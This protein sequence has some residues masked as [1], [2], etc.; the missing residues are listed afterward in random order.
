MDRAGSDPEKAVRQIPGEMDRLSL[1]EFPQTGDL[2]QLRANF[3][4]SGSQPASVAK[5][6]LLDFERVS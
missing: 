4:G 5:D 6:G 3:L 1:H 2:Q